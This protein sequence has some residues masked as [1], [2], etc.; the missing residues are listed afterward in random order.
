MAPALC[1]TGALRNKP[2]GV[3]WPGTFSGTL[4]IHLEG[5]SSALRDQPRD[6]PRGVHWPGTFSDTLTIHLEGSSRDKCVWS[7]ALRPLSPLRLVA[8]VDVCRPNT[9][10]RRRGYKGQ[11]RHCAILMCRCTP[12]SCCWPG[13]PNT[14]A[15]RRGRKGQHRHCA[16]LLF[17]CTSFF[18]FGFGH[19]CVGVRVLKVCGEIVVRGRACIVLRTAA[20]L[21]RTPSPKGDSRKDSVGGGGVPSSTPKP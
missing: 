19:P 20:A 7:S 11:H 2:R 4:A 18:Y 12:V 14:L 16:I 10:A 6:G 9:L 13:R 3:H 21:S 5:P 1:W 8:L 15:R 17:R